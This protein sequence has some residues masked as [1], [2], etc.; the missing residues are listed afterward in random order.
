VEPVVDLV[1]S[2][3]ADARR[4]AVSSIVRPGNGK[5]KTIRSC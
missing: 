1:R 2:S 5:R 4:Y 3:D